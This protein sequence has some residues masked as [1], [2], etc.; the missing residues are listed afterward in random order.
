MVALD[1]LRGGE[2][3]GE[4]AGGRRLNA[5]GFFMIDE[6][7]LATLPDEA[8]LELHRSGLMALI[9]AHRVS[10][11]HVQTLAARLPAAR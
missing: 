6:Q 2:I 3:R 7:R 9:H 8:V 5:T 4:I 10:M 11:G 1:L